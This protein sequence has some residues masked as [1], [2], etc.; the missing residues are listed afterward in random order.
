MTQLDNLLSIAKQEV[1][2]LEKE[3]KSD[4]EDKTANAGDKNY[5][6]YAKDLDAIKYFNGGKQGVAWC[7]VFVNW[8]FYKAFGATNAK[9]MLCQPQKESC[10]AGCGSA[11]GYFAK[12]NRFSFTPSVGDQIFFYAMGSSEISH[13]GI[14]VKITDSKVYTIEGNTSAGSQVIPNGGSVCEKSYART[15]SRICGYGHP[16][17]SIVEPREVIK[18]IYEG[19]V[20]CKPGETVN[21]RKSCSTNASVLC[22]VKSGEKVSVLGKVNDTWEQVEYNNITGY[23]MREFISEYAPDNGETITIKRSDLVNIRDLLNNL[24]K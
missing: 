21:L 8:C 7:A 17:W 12:A 20:N 15:N 3:T 24:L 14:V 11:K 10:G 4:L 2:Y 19:F 16:D 13:T 6:K 23:M 22:K 9:K 18:V 5:T 1:G